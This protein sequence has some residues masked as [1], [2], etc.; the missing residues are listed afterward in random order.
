[1]AVEAVVG[2]IQLAIGK[3]FVKRG[4][5]FVQHLGKRLFPRNIVARQLAPEALVIGI[6]FVTQ[7]IVC[8]H[9]VDIGVGF[10]FVARFEHP[11][12]FQHG[13]NGRHKVSPFIYSRLNILLL[14]AA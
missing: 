3:P 11:I 7:G 4:V 10:E 8:I 12:F 1:M 5:A 6:R 14:E 2:H 9:A 13:F